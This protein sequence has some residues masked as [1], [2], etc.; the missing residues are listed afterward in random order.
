MTLTDSPTHSAVSAIPPLF[1]NRFERSLRFCYLEFDKEVIVDG[2]MAHSRVFMGGGIL[3][4]FRE[5]SLS[6]LMNVVTYYLPSIED[7]ISCK[8][9]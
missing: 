5:L 1:V 2:F 8:I 4:D 7:M 3:S 9:L 6:Y